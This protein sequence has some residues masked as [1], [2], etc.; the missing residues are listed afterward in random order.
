MPPSIVRR[1]SV[2]ERRHGEGSLED[3]RSH[4]EDGL[5]P[6]SAKHVLAIFARRTII[7][8]KMINISSDNRKLLRVPLKSKI[9]GIADMKACCDFFC[10]HYES[11]GVLPT[12][13]SIVSI[14]AIISIKILRVHFFC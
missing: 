8:V 1:L 12:F 3:L 6:R 13:T 9:R 2:Q 10:L 4:G 7:F 14:V 5:A 11:S